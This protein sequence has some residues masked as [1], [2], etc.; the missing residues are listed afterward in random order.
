VLA[1]D[2]PVLVHNT[3]PGC[4]WRTYDAADIARGHA[5]AKHGA[6][7]PGM[8]ASDLEKHAEGVMTNPSRTK[9]L[10]R[11]RKAYLGQ[12]RETI[13]IHDPVHE[14]GGTIFRRGAD[15]M[16]EYWEGLR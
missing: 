6:E 9:D 10:A 1:D 2:T 5:N 4:D 14:D 12:D 15:V 3:G 16:D 8:S 7:F 11:N 13:V